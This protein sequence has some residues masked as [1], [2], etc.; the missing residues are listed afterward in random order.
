MNTYVASTNGVEG[1]PN[2][3]PTTVRCLCGVLEPDCALEEVVAVG[4]TDA[5]CLPS[6]ENRR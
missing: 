6:S 1:P 2:L 5:A 4:G 3:D